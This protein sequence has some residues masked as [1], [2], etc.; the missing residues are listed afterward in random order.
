M[1]DEIFLDQRSEVPHLVNWG[2]LVGEGQ[3]VR[4]KK[5]AEARKVQAHQ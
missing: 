5:G 3:K 1:D 4:K 2:S